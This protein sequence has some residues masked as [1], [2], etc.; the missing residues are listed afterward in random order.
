[1]SDLVMKLTRKRKEYIF[2]GCSLFNFLR[3]EGNIKPAKEHFLEWI[4][5]F[6]GCFRV[7]KFYLA[8]RQQILACYI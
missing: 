3:L 8:E 6:T 4:A 5:L 7:C 2:L 1:M